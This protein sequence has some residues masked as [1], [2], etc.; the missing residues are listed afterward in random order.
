MISDFG[1]HE[2]DVAF[3]LRLVLSALAILLGGKSYLVQSFLVLFVLDK[4][5]TLW[6]QQLKIEWTP[7]TKHRYHVLGEWTNTCVGWM[8]FYVYN[9]L[10]VR[11][12]HRYVLLFLL[13]TRT[14]SVILYSYGFVSRAA[15]GPHVFS[16]AWILVLLDAQFVWF[17]TLIPLGFVQHTITVL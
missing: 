10:V 6:V 4:L 12:W 3:L 15:V 14:L 7:E 8:I 2:Y 5:D 17:A 16:V 9:S 13:V 11:D 1:S